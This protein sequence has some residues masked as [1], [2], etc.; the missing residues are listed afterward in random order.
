M[1]MGKKSKC[2]ESMKAK[3]NSVYRSYEDSKGMFRV[4][5]NK[6]QWAK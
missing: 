4:L 2:D 6:V 1:D 3:I 5:E